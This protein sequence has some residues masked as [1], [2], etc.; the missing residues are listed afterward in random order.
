MPGVLH[1]GRSNVVLISLTINTLRING[2]RG[3]TSEGPG[4]AHLAYDTTAHGG[5]IWA[6]LRQVTR[7]DA[8]R[9]LHG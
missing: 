4:A 2:L 7:Y 1:I 3:P 6:A 5:V 9:L 8:A